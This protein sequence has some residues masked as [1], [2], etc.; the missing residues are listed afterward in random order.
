MIVDRSYSI[1]DIWLLGI[2][3]GSNALR[4]SLYDATTGKVYPLSL[5]RVMTILQVSAASL[6]ISRSQI[7]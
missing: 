2:D 4:A 3:F 5:M 7:H 6:P 1:D